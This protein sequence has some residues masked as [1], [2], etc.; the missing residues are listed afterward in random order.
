MVTKVKKA[1]LL[2]R[3]LAALFVLI[4]SAEVASAELDRE[5]FSLVGEALVEVG[6]FDLDVYQ[7][8][9]FTRNSNETLVELTYLRE[10]SGD[11]RLRRTTG[12]VV[13]LDRRPLPHDPA[14]KPD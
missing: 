9:H 6:P 3:A 14:Q 5:S 4:T 8:R 12:I 11:H 2:V 1:G 10:V 13:A 7:A